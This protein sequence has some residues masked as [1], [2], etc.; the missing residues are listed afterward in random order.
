LSSL[1]NDPRRRHAVRKLSF[2]YKPYSS[3]TLVRLLRGTLPKLIDVIDLDVRVGHS[4]NTHIFSGCAFK[5]KRFTTDVLINGYLTSFLS[6]QTCLVDLSLIHS[7][8][9]LTFFPDDL[10]P[11]LRIL[12]AHHTVVTLLAPRR[13][14]ETIYVLGAVQMDDLRTLLPA[15]HQTKAPLRELKIDLER[16]T[17]E[18]LNLIAF[19]LPTLSFLRVHDCWQSVPSHENVNSLTPAT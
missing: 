10:L 3:Q 8:T 15:C 12:T 17:T 19:Q 5:L 16:C 4:H 1:I 18:S 2:R 6:T 13:P 7:G 9:R 11:N 14:L